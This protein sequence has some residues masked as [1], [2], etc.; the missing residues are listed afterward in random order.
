MIEIMGNY[1]A[2]WLKINLQN[3]VG[4]LYTCYNENKA[5]KYT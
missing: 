2:S 5:Q 1:Y 4:Y 3:S